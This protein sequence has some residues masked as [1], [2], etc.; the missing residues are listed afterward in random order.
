MRVHFVLLAEGTALDIAADI[1]GEAR[2][3]EF[4]GD[5]LAS[6]QEARVTGGFMIM[7]AV[8]N[9]ASEGIIRRDVDAAFVR[10]NTGL[11][12]PIS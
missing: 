12:L 7:A 2:P 9:G 5:K 6:F 10:K 8:E 11:D 4:S 3:P 1:G